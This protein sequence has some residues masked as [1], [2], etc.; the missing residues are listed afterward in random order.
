MCVQVCAGQ[1][2]PLCVSPAGIRKKEQLVR[3][4]EEQEE[5]EQQSRRNMDI[6]LLR[7][8]YRCTRETQRRHTHVLL[9]RTVSEELSEVVVSVSQGFTSP[10][11]VTFDPDPWRVH[12]EL[13]R[14]CCPGVTDSSSRRSSSSSES[15]KLSSCSSF[16]STTEEVNVDGSRGDPDP[17]SSGGNPGPGSSGGDPGPGSSD[18]SRGDPEKTDPVQV[19]VSG[20]LG[21]RKLSAPALRFTRQLSLGGVGSSTGV[22]Q[23][24][25][26][27]QSY[28]PFPNRKTPRI[29]ESA[30]RLG[31]YSSF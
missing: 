30:R 4:E 25:T 5:Q 11:D 7:E 22:H 27:N 9:L 16:C 31:M 3:R 6:S 24:Q 18:G 26:Q 8:Q 21:S 29:S 20:S 19:S 17:G 1:R 15:R 2:S 13:H 28:H 14:R 23:N 10:P 12:L